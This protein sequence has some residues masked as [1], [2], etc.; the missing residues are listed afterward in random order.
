M[1]LAVRCMNVG[2]G[3]RLV[4]EVEIL[5]VCSRSRRMRTPTVGGRARRFRR[6][7]A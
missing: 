2:R 6:A 1:L 5:A 4:V 3:G 7:G